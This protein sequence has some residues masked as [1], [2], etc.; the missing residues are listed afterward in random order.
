VQVALGGEGGG[1]VRGFEGADMVGRGGGARG[2]GR[3]RGSGLRGVGGGG[4]QLFLLESGVAS[5]LLI[6]TSVHLHR[7]RVNFHSK[8][9]ACGQVL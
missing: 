1:M 5:L 4:D 9:C 8:V 3:G 6:R 2:R 7:V